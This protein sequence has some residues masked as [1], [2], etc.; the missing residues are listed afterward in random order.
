MTAASIAL[1]GTSLTRGTDDATHATLAY[2]DRPAALAGVLERTCVVK[3]RI[4]CAWLLAAIS[5]VVWA[6]AGFRQAVETYMASGRTAA[7]EHLGP[8]LR[9]A[10][11]QRRAAFTA[12][13]WHAFAHDDRRF[14]DGRATHHA[15][16]KCSGFP[17]LGIRFARAGE[18][19]YRILGY[20][21]AGL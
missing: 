20:W 5:P 3:L 16:L 1:M 19:R 18:Y 15:V 12:C 4:C 2:N 21:T 11:E 17:D 9:G 7:F 10:L 13:A 6:E 14:G 8:G